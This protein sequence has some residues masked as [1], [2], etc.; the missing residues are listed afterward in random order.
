MMR[1]TCFFAAS[2]SVPCRLSSLMC[3]EPFP[4]CLALP[5]VSR[6][7]GTRSEGMGMKSE[8]ELVWLADG[9]TERM[10]GRQFSINGSA[11]RE[12]VF[13]FSS[14]CRCQ[15][16]IF[17]HKR[18]GSMTLVELKASASTRSELSSYFSLSLDVC[19]SFMAMMSKT[20]VSSD[21]LRATARRST[22]TDILWWNMTLKE[23]TSSSS[24]KAL[25]L[26]G[27]LTT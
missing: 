13:F 21:H 23:E 7:F 9:Q 11:L 6:E 16:E 24:L 25:S 2:A 27:S 4:P 10:A 20:N 8:L 1:M 26:M 17:F 12:A 15:G 22:R 14:F 3:R 18:S 5:A 19:A